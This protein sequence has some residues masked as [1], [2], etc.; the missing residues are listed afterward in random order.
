M[1][2]LNKSNVFILVHFFCWLIL[3]TGV[4]YAHPTDVYLT[5]TDAF[6]IRQTILLIILMSVFYLNFYLLI[7][8]ILIRRHVIAYIAVVIV[9]LIA[10]TSLNNLI[11]SVFKLTAPFIFN[12]PHMPFNGPRPPFNGPGG[13]PDHH[14]HFDT[15]VPGM[16][17][18][19]IGLGITISFIR[20]WQQEVNLR[21]QLEQEQAITE[22]TLLKAQIN[23]HFFFNT[24]NT[25]YSYTLSDGDVARTAITNLSKMM[26]YV[27]YDADGRQTPLNKEITFIR[28]Y[29]E[30]MKLRISKKTTV[31]LQVHELPGEAM[32]APMLFLPFVEN[33]FKHGVSGITEGHISIWILQNAESVELIVKNT[34]YDSRR[35]SE[36]ESNGIGILNT[37][38]RL[39]LLYPGKYTLVTGLISET[40]YEV[41]LKL[42]L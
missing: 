17:L 7:P 10:V 39:E 31:L 15:F 40:E 41:K 28:E 16:N 1:K 29:I 8:R 12:G 2:V 20:K 18:L 27:L 25:I 6:W 3:A 23:P 19:M 9:L 42:A 26:R 36:E 11:I 35:A 37:T 14:G 4:L 38:R 33:A 30:L 24:L 21:Q 34:V 22:L 32:I 5:V 13:R